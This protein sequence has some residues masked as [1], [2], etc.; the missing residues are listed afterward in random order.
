MRGK[1]FLVL[2]ILLAIAVL[3]VLNYRENGVKTAP[4]Y[5][6]SSMH[7]FRLTHKEKD[8][9]KWELMADKAI[10]PKGNQE[11]HLEALTMKV[12]HE[13][14]VA[15]KGGSG[16]Y[17]IKK[18]TLIVNKPIEINIEGARLTTDSLTWNGRKGLL[19][20]QDPIQFQDE[21]FLI[22]GTGLSANVKD[23]RIRILNDVKGTFYH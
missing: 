6:V 17:N 18:K 22:E 21:K 19:M 16:V 5:K 14:E 7:G 4:S 1:F 9:I 15:L 3:A 12:H 11:V 20:T 10:F 23:Q 2:L 13:Q 8:E